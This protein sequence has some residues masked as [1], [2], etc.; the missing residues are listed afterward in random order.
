MKN[1]RLFALLLCV[2]LIASMTVACSSSNTGTGSS[3]GTASTATSAGTDTASTAE[4]SAD[5][6]PYA[7]Q[8]I[9]FVTANQPC[10]EN[11][12]QSSLNEFTEKTGIKVN[13]EVMGTDQFTNKV[14]VELSAQSK[15]LDLIFLRP[16]N[17]LKQFV[18]NDWLTDLS[19]YFE[20]DEE[21]D[22]ADFF[23]GAVN[24]CR[25]EDTLYGLPL[26]AESQLVYYRKDIFEQKGIT[27]PKTMDEFMEVA[28]QLTDKE[29]GF[30]GVVGRG[31]SN[32][33]ITQFSTF[34]RAFGGDFNTSNESL[35]SKPEAVEAINY[36]G[37]LLYEYGPPG[38]VNMSWP[39]GAALFAQGKAAMFFDAD[40]IYSNVIDAENTVLKPEQIGYAMM[41][42]GPAG[43]TPFY[44][45]SAA[46]AIPSFS[47][48][49]DASA[50]FIR[51]ALSKEMD[52]K[53]MINDKNPGCRQ[54]SWENPEATASWPADLLEVMIDSREVAVAGD[55]PSVIN[56]VEARD[57]ISLPIMT[58]MQGQDPAAA[59]TKAHS[60]FQAL[61]DKE[62]TK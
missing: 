7:G 59:I 5:A 54:S 16:L 34:L 24:S 45:V 61:I 6:K 35:I 18:Q 17:D 29:N 46:V 21:F 26:V 31:K 42:A 32:A 43:N 40:A 23:E 1:K 10:V 20:N 14:T 15:N 50:E 12:L 39:E 55:R 4:S 8:T 53:M 49:K 27:F 48:K 56:V 62:N 36:Y 28:K 22:L 52:I 41:P 9:R 51:W 58:A 44:A 38:V 30:Y 25:Y 37:K 60:D 47:E 11:T 57:I 19:S 13:M 2:V 33:C 3:S